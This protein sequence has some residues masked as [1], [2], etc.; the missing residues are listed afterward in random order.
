M[1]KTIQPVKKIKPLFDNILVAPFLEE[2]TSTGIYLPES[3]GPKG[4]VIAVGEGRITPEGK[5]IP[6]S[7][8]VGQIIVY[9]NRSFKVDGKDGSQNLVENKIIVDGKE[10][11]VIEEKDILAIVE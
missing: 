3:K 11:I 7:V 2:K 8:K 6:V 5:V 9:K 1:A 10:W 4:T